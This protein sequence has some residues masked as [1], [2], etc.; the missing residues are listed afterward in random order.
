MMDSDPQ[1]SYNLVIGKIT[2]ILW[3][4][5]DSLNA[6]KIPSNQMVSDVPTPW[7]LTH[8]VPKKVILIIII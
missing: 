4:L 5:V 6:A 2:F 8:F 7:Y 3:E 1:N